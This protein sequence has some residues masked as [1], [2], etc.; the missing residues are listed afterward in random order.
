M[1]RDHYIPNDCYNASI[2][3]EVFLRSSDMKLSTFRGLTFHRQNLP[4]VQFRRS[5][6]IGPVRHYA[7]AEYS[8]LKNDKKLPLFLLLFI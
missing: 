6:C 4:S 1:H 8:L 5:P 3:V 2:D 7:S